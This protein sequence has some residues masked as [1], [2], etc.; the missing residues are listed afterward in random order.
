[1]SRW[2]NSVNNLLQKLDGT[3]E[4]AAEEAPSVLESVSTRAV[5]LARSSI[6]QPQRQQQQQQRQ[7]NSAAAATAVASSSSSHVASSISG[8]EEEDSVDSEDDESAV[9]NNDDDDDADGELYSTAEEEIVSAAAS[10]ESSSLDEN[11]AKVEDPPPEEAFLVQQRLQKSV[12]LENE[13][14]SV[15]T[16]HSTNPSTAAP[17]AATT[18]LGNATP[19]FEE[20]IAPDT[21]IEP[22]A[23]PELFLSLPSQQAKDETSSA[24]AIISETAIRGDS[25]SQPTAKQSKQLRTPN[26]LKS[27]PSGPPGIENTTDALQQQKHFQQQ[28]ANLKKQH[29]AEIAKLQKQNEVALQS[30][31]QRNVEQQQQL[32]KTRNNEPLLRQELQAVRTELVAVNKELQQAAVT[33]EQERQAARDERDELLCEQEEELQQ[34]KQDYEQQM[35]QM[36]ETMQEQKHH[37]H[38]QLLATEQQRQVLEGNLS[39]ELA[40]VTAR[41]QAALQRVQALELANVTLQN[42]VDEW[43]DKQRATKQQWQSVTDRL[44]VTEAAVV[45][46]EERLDEVVAQHQHQLQQRLAR[47]TALEKTVAE[48]SHQTAAAAA[49]ATAGT[50]T[51]SVVAASTEKEQLAAATAAAQKHKKDYELAAQELG[52]IQLE[53]T[54][55]SQRCDA[56]Q[57]ELTNVSKERDREIASSQ[58]LLRD[59]EVRLQELAVNHRLVEQVKV[60]N[61]GIPSYKS[62]IF[63]SGSSDLSEQHVEQLTRELDQC[64]KQVV[65]LSD[66]LVRQQGIAETSKSEILAL[67]GRLQVATSRAEAAERQ[68]ATVLSEIESGMAAAPPQNHY[69]SAKTRQQQRRIK[70][71]QARFGH[72]S[73]HS[74]RSAMGL[75]H[76][77]VGNQV[78]Q[79]IGNTID[80]LDTWMLETGSI[81][82]HEPLARLGFALYLTIIHVWCFGLV[83]FHTIESEHGDLGQ[84]TNH[85]G[86]LQ[87]RNK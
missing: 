9:S 46:A 40:Q 3:V 45:A 67:K 43:R 72:L 51:T 13:N 36:R 55:A 57:Q 49:A 71:G 21:A 5:H 80:A 79:Q 32:Q 11:Q 27:S 38:A 69:S 29:A 34:L 12:R 41:E 6:A 42:Q 8:S 61:S 31:A 52:T 10:Y 39:A 54:L 25:N 33:V 85:V 17:N 73:S 75:R 81:F 14:S 28:I 53:L 37:Y 83:F 63:S 86:V 74:M 23:A 47:E 77:G 68:Q 78:K 4:N 35:Q 62:N 60:G 7:G 70:G 58:T 30:V 48:L 50:K 64:K 82:R 15:S 20:A 76:G 16:H 26:V 18:T 24:E 65:S 22:I 59:Y 1:M 19:Y 87:H 84:L 66:Q 2:L 44:V 56:L